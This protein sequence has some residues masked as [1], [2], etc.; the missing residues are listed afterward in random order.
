M[1]PNEL[2][3][4]VSMVGDTYQLAQEVSVSELSQS[5]LAGAAVAAPYVSVNGVGGSR[6]DIVGTSL[7]VTEE[8]Y[9]TLSAPAA[10]TFQVNP[11]IANGSS[12]KILYSSTNPP[13]FGTL[14]QEQ[15]SELNGIS[16]T[17]TVTTAGLY[18]P[19]LYTPK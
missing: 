12:Y 2:V 15:Y 5:Q 10:L 13:E 19:V 6:V 3:D 4:S 9:T 11:N 18:M 1:F 7:Y 17:A 16:L 14:W 8:N